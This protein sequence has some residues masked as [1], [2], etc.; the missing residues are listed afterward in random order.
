MYSVFFTH[1]TVSPLFRSLSRSLALTHAHIHIDI[2]RYGLF[3][4]AA[5][6]GLINAVVGQLGVAVLA[7][8]LPGMGARQTEAHETFYR[9]YARGASRL[10]AMV[11]EVQSALDFI[12]CA[13]TRGGG[14]AQCS[15][16]S[17]HAGPYS[18]L[19]V[20]TLDPQR[21]Y[22]LGYSMGAIVG[23]H[24]AALI[25]SSRIAGVAAFGGWTP[26]KE[27]FGSVAT[28]GNRFLYEKHALIPRLGL[29]RNESQLLYDY[30]ELISSL[31]PRPV[32]LHA[33]LRNRFAQPA[34]V[35]AAATG[36]AMAWE[37]AGASADFT[38]VQPN[39]TSDFKDAEI[40]AAL[41]W[42]ERVLS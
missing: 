23:L 7:W 16:G 28:G 35:A 39:A 1:A 24:A 5:D 20:P 26:F 21:V 3:D 22:L 4:S 8:D 27:N 41:Q 25:N 15:D 14:D 2:V 19:A 11:G 17:S 6:G 9:R 33:P 30:E 36:A 31:A 18:A 32:L 12:R 42:L 13:G 38:F 37:K 10:G 40:A 34:A 29:F